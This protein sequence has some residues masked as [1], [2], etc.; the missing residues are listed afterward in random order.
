MVKTQQQD[1]SPDHVRRFWV[2]RS[3]IRKNPDPWHDVTIPG[4]DEHYKGTELPRAPLIYLEEEDEYGVPV[5][6]ADDRPDDRDPDQD[7]I[8]RTN[9]ELRLVNQGVPVKRNPPLQGAV[10]SQFPCWTKLFQTER[11]EAGAGTGKSIESAP[12]LR[13]RR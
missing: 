3:L 10:A 8:D 4:L 5:P 9:E 12:G 11:T 1:C 2:N 7:V 13:G 6:V